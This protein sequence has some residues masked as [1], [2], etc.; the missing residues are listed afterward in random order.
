MLD[1]KPL[2]KWETKDY[3]TYVPP[4]F[5]VIIVLFSIVMFIGNAGMVAVVSLFALTVSTTPYMLYSYHRSASVRVIEDQLPNFLRDLVETSRSGMT[6]TQAMAAVSKSDYGKLSPEI[7]KIHSQLSWGLPIERVLLDFADRIKESVLIKRNMRIIIEA[8]RSGGDII[9]TMEAIA[10]DATIIK[11]AEKEKRS[12]LSQHVVVMYMI[13]FMFIAIVLVLSKVLLP[14]TQLEVNIAGGGGSSSP[15]QGYSGGLNFICISFI[16]ATCSIFGFG[17]SAICYYK[18]IF[19]YMVVIQGIFA[20]LV[21]GQIGEDS[22]SA[23]TKHSL[24]M[25]G[26]GFT[27]FLIATFLKIA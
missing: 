15:C 2:N 10:T 26:T 12:K 23:G 6:F 16:P 4:L 11:E 17:G 25:A 8:H 14:L 13:Y 9:D 7:A 18:S 27:V 20:G 3:V 19:F 24:I 1:I 22:I 21:A 5:G